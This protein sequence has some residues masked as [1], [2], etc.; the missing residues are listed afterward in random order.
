MIVAAPGDLA[1][2][3]RRMCLRRSQRISPIPTVSP[4][5]PE[6][7][8]SP[9]RI[10]RWPT[11]AV[12]RSSQSGSNELSLS[13]LVLGW[14]RGTHSS[15][16]FLRAS[17]SR[18]SVG[19]PISAAGLSPST[20]TQLTRA[21]PETAFEEGSG[22]APFLFPQED[23]LLVTEYSFS[24]EAPSIAALAR[25]ES[26]SPAVGRTATGGAPGPHPRLKANRPATPR[27]THRTSWLKGARSGPS[28]TSPRPAR[29]HRY[30]ND[31]SQSPCAAL[32]V[33]EVSERDTGKR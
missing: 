6:D 15:F 17:S 25:S 3:V 20:E 29:S 21:L 26:F 32:Q 10:L 5:F 23:D 16:T 19:E 30:D 18:P 14:G 9:A 24:L 13:L 11:P 31:T 7:A 12:S 8:A 28:N 1:H 27:N 4:A 22:R 33:H 2:E